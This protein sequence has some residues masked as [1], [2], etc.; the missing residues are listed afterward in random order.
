MCP[1]NSLELKNTYTDKHIQHELICYDS[2]GASSM[3]GFVIITR[4]MDQT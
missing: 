4:E 3:V 1:L 2:R